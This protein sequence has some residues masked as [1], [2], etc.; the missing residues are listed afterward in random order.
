VLGLYS[1]EVQNRVYCSAVATSG[2]NTS[3]QSEDCFYNLLA[4][5]YWG[6]VVCAR[7]SRAGN[8]SQT[9]GSNNRRQS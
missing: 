9:G 3:E 8:L 1:S 6:H 2:S 7:L 5:I 4:L